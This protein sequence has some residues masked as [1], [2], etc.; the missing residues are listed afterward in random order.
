VDGKLTYRVTR[1]MAEHYGKWS[2]DTPKFVI[3]NFALGG[4]YPFKT[5]GIEVPYSGIPASTVARI[6]QG[7]IAMLVDW[8]R[9]Y[10][11]NKP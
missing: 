6:K 2:F 8:V 1:K 10:G 7:D 3:L 4:A 9:V 11:R 5:N